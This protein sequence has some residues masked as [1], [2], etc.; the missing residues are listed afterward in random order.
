M[1]SDRVVGAIRPQGPEQEAAVEHGTE[2]AL[3]DQQQPELAGA[4]DVA[5]S[6]LRDS[7]PRARSRCWHRCRWSGGCCRSRSSG[8]SGAVDR[9]RRERAADLVA[10]AGVEARLHDPGRAATARRPPPP[11]MSS[12]TSPASTAVRP[13]DASRTATTTTADADPD[14]HPAVERVD[15][16]HQRDREHR[17]AAIRRRHDPST[18]H[19]ATNQTSS[20]DRLLPQAFVNANGADGRGDVSPSTGCSCAELDL[21]A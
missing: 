8:W 4:A 16:R 3:G 20:R 11:T 21:T 2:E 10:V 19:P 13:R 5:S 15:D 7:P 12:P 9:V 1:P 17:P 6:A 18:P 14:P